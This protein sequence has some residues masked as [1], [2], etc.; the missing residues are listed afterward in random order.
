MMRFPRTPVRSLLAAGL[1]ALAAVPGYAGSGEL[2]KLCD[3]YWQGYLQAHPTTATAIGDR[4]YDDR[5]EDNSPAGIAR[6]THRLEGLLTRA[7]AVPL[8]ELSSRDRLDRAA[9]IEELDSQLMVRSCRFER[10]NVDPL[11]GPQSEL[12]DLPDFTVIK[13]P[14]DAAH[15]V[16]RCRAMSPYLANH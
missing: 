15:F 9:L 2:A 5:L 11:N 8:K 12:M 10:W 1:L 7:R 13:T 14:A 4:R 3:E 6:E 16:A